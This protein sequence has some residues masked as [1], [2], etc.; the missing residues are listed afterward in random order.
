MSMKKH[1]LLLAIIFLSQINFAQSVF[2]PYYFTNSNNITDALLFS[3]YY[4]LFNPR[5]KA[6]KPLNYH[7]GFVIDNKNDT[8]NGNIRLRHEDDISM[9]IKRDGLNI[10]TLIRVSDVKLVRLFDTDSLLNNQVYTD[11]VRIGKNKHDLWRQVYKGNFE[12][13]DELYSSN[14][15]PG[16]VGDYLVV[17]ENNT[18]KTI[19]G[20]WTISPT[21]N[22]IEY[23]NQKYDKSFKPNTFRNSIEVINWLKRNG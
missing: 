21:R 23:V 7:H 22:M 10:D 1:I 6:V 14:E 3:V 5:H 4:D 12:I 15:N 17:K 16:K 9:I 18:I 13:Y 20:F 2:Y 11:Y 19:A 8:L